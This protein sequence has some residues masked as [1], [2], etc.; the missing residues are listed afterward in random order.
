MT[1]TL[2]LDYDGIIIESTEK[3]GF[4]ALWQKNVHLDFGENFMAVRHGLN[5][6][7]CT[8][9]RVGWN[10]YARFPAPFQLDSAYWKGI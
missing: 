1:R 4:S 3:W 5:K 2:Q 7:G 10:I 6:I 8:C 9:S